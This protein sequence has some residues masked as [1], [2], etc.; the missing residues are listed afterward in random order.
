[1]THD[2]TT[3]TAVKLV[4]WTLESGVGADWRTHEGD[5][6]GAGPLVSSDLRHAELIGAALRSNSVVPGIS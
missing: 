4:W 1:M 6:S 5:S 2:T 3:S